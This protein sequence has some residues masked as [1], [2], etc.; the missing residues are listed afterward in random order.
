M[1]NNTIMSGVLTVPSLSFLK[2]QASLVTGAPIVYEEKS[3][4]NEHLKILADERP[5]TDAIPIMN[6]MVVGQRG[7]VG[8][9]DEDDEVW[10]LPISHEPTDSAP[11]R[12]VPLV[13]R[14]HD[15]DLTE[16]QRENYALRRLVT[17]ATKRYWAYYAKRLP[18]QA[19]VGKNWK[20]TKKDGIENVEEFHYTDSNLY[21]TPPEVASN[22]LDSSNRVNSTNTDGQYVITRVT[23]EI[24]FDSFDTAEYMNVAAILK[25]NPLKAILSEIIPCT[26]VDKIVTV[27][28]G[29]GS[30]FQFKEVIGCQ[31]AFF[32]SCYH[33][34]AITNSKVGYSIEVGQTKPM[35]LRATV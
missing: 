24:E 20:I 2:I 35:K 6:Y 1:S 3:T 9:M 34:L 14:E 10:T 19:E 16:A 21:P 12:I 15:N 4:I 27:D 30:S 26:G 22:S 29:D 18:R 31:P 8:E 17:H 33:N 25:N 7:H 11:Y 32:L 13:M 28:A 5:A 23:R